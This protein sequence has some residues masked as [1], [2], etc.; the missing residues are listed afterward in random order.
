PGARPRDRRLG[1]GGPARSHPRRAAVVDPRPR[2]VQGHD[3]GGRAV[4][5]ARL[6][7]R[8]TAAG[9]ALRG[10]PRLMRAVTDNDNPARSLAPI[11]R[12]AVLALLPLSL[13]CGRD[14]NAPNL[15]KDNPQLPACQAQ[16]VVNSSVLTCPA[17]SYCDPDS[18]VLPKSP[19]P[20]GV[21]P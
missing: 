7:A 8:G 13:S 2:G 14:Q 5:G 11:A 19:V 20:E 15:C 4:E 3:R 21:D 10:E 16:C 12:L 17:G 1:G 6:G 18:P 9:A